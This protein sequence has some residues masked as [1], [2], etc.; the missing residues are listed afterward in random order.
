MSMFLLHTREKKAAHERRERKA[1]MA[2]TEIHLGAIVA[3]GAIGA[4]KQDSARPRPSHTALPLTR[5]HEAKAKACWAKGLPLK[6]FRNDFQ[7][8]AESL[9]PLSTRSAGLCT[10]ADGR[11]GASARGG[12]CRRR[13]GGVRAA[14]GGGARPPR[15][16]WP[17]CAV[18]LPPRVEARRCTYGRTARGE[19]PEL[20]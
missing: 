8:H 16:S 7:R 9:L 12:A 10:V 14:C 1:R 11:L 15:R 4:S 5:R 18:M 20:I 19:L 3:I 6:D 17:T 13:A 2:T